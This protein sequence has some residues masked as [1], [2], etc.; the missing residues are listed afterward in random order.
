MGTLRVFVG[1]YVASRPLSRAY[2]AR[3]RWTGNA[4]EAFAG[5]AAIAE[6]LTE[7]NANGFLAA[8]ADKSPFTIRSY[9]SDILTLWNAAADCDLVAYPVLRR[10][11]AARVP[12][13]VVDCYSLEEARAILGAAAGLVGRYRHGVSRRAYWESAI[14]LAWDSGL[15]RGDVVAFRRDCLRSDG[16]YAVCQAKTRKVVR[17]R[18]HASTVEALAAIGGVYPLR[19]SGDLV[20]FTRQFRRLVLEAGVGRGSFKWLRRSSGSHVETDQPGAGYKHLGQA[21]PDVFRRYYDAHLGP[22]SLPQ[23]PEL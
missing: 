14:R 2:A 21:G 22:H 16:S 19:W 13:L 23:P 1:Q 7:A 12:E 8:Q 15:R 9:R 17:G 3:L 6:V 11:R 20:Y 5:S 18:L 10:V 4:L